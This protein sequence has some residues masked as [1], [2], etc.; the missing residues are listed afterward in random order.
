MSDHASFKFLRDKDFAYAVNLIE[1][2]T[3][4]AGKPDYLDDLRETVQDLDLFSR[5]SGRARSTRLFEWLAAKMSFQGISD[6]VAESYMTDHGRP[7]WG[8]IAKGVKTATCPLLKSYWH[9]HGCRYRKLSRTCALPALIDTCPLPQ[10]HFRN[11]NLNQLAYSLF[12]FIRDVAGG[13]LVGWIDGRLTEANYGPDRI[14]QMADA[15]IGPLAGVHGVAGKVLNMV[16]AD[17]LVV[18]NAHNPRWGEVGGS[19]IAIDTLV[20]NFL[21]RT[22]ILKRATAVHPYG[23]QCYG[24][25]GCAAILSGLSEA[26]DARQFNSAFP[27]VFPRYVQRAIWAYCAEEGLRVCN[28]RSIDDRHRCKNLDCRLYSMCDRV[29]LRGKALSRPHSRP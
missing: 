14:R 11:G 18:G 10:H 21:V 12:L 4:L 28:G 3:W 22:G 25:A 24:P 19:L 15:I 16:L 8:S 5:S 13:D 9:F 26:I 29:A 6:R 2:V 27:R 17:L 1:T 20:H 7:R 23:P